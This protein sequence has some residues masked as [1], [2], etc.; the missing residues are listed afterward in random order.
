MSFSGPTKTNKIIFNKEL[1]LRNFN[2]VK[3][4]ILT[5]IRDP[6]S[7][8]FD[9]SKIPQ[10][11]KNNNINYQNIEYSYITKLLSEY[12]AHKSIQV[13]IDSLTNF[14]N[15]NKNEL[16]SWSV[17]LAQK[18]GDP[19]ELTNVNFELEFY[20]KNNVLQTQKIT[21]LRRKWNELDDEKSDLRT[22]S[23]FLDRGSKDNSFDII[24]ENNK[25]EFENN[26]AQSTIKYRNLKKKPILIVYPVLYNGLLFPLFYFIIPAINGGKKVQYIVRNNR[27]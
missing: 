26:H 8:L 9:N 5:I 3:D 22:I 1:Q 13:D 6:K 23:Q 20:N 10:I 27:N 16:N 21:G 17:V 11:V 2:R 7:N 12:E 19:L 14:I 24:D 25:G 15:E 4:F 18:F